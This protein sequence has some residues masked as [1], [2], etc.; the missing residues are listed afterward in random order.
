[1]ERLNPGRSAFRPPLSPSLPCRLVDQE[2]VEF[3]STFD[4]SNKPTRSCATT[5]PSFARRT[6][7]FRRDFLSLQCASTLSSGHGNCPVHSLQLL[8]KLGMTLRKQSLNPF[9][10]IY[11]FFNGHP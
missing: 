9:S 7:I 5:C 1:M 6:P 11:E 3:L 8:L 4:R 10:Q 2:I